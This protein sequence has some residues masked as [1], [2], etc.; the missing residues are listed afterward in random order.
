MSD[1]VGL[2]R[3][4]HIIT[5]TGKHPF[6]LIRKN[7]HE[8]IESLIKG[9]GDIAKAFYPKPVWYRSIDIRSDEFRELE[10]GE[11]ESSENN[12]LM[13]WHGIRRSLDQPDL[14]KI[15]IEIIERLYKEG[16]SNIV[17]GI[18]FLTSMEEFRA[19]K[20][21]ARFPL[22]IGVMVDTPAAGLEI[23]NLCKEGIAFAAIGLNDLTQLTLG[24]DRDNSSISKLYSELNPAVINLLKH[25]LRTCR[26]YSVETSVYGDFVSDPRIAEALVKLGVGSISTEPEN[27]EDV[28]SIITRTERKIILESMRNHPGI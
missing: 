14:L 20:Q 12:P 23:E 18:P 13:G 24:V 7:P 2:I 15:E 28:K 4:E 19:V 3:A 21:M 8:I 9:L 26:K 10:G 22:K 5:E 11:Y 16:L 27:L 17:L 1:G 25:I 6:Y